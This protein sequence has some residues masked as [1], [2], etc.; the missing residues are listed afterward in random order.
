[1]EEV[2]KD[3]DCTCRYEI[4]NLGKIRVKSTKKE[5]KLKRYNT[6]YLFIRFGMPLHQEVARKF[7]GPRKKGYVVHHVNRDRLNNEVGNL[8]YITASEHRQLDEFKNKRQKKDKEIDKT[9]STLKS[10]LKMAKREKIH[11]RLIKER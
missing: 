8:V 7:I 9:I 10:E 3:L 4:S 2:W 11:R 1:M 5:K 6:A